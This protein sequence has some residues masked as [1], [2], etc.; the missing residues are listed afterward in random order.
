MGQGRS[1]NARGSV[2]WPA[3]WSRA[4]AGGCL[5]LIAGM[6]A[7]TDGV[8]DTGPAGA[9]GDGAVASRARFLMGTRLSI[10]IPARARPEVFEAAFAEV[11][12]LE[13]VMSNWRP[14]S[15]I[16]ALNRTAAARPFRCSVDLF[17]AVAASLRLAEETGGAFDPTV[18]PLVNR[19]GLRSADG[20]LPDDPTP[21][22]EGGSPPDGPVGW[23]HVR[24][25]P[26]HLSVFFDSPG[27]GIDLGGIGKGIAL[28]AA[29]R[30]LHEQGVRAALLDFGGQA[31]AVGA[32]PGTSGW[33]LGIAS[34]EDRETPRA[35]VLLKDASLAGSGNGERA[36]QS[37]GGSLGHILDPAT[38]SPAR[39]SGTVSVVAGDGT[40]AD[41]LSTALFVMGPDAGV[42]W[43]ETRGVSVQFAWV[44]EGGAPRV[45]GSS[46]FARLAANVAV[47]D[48]TGESP[49]E[50]P[51]GALTRSGEGP[52][53]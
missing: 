8:R 31:M 50:E 46:A 19:L 24:L 20:R 44:D 32:P 13:Q 43:A 2:A 4:L 16:M 25:D 35:A 34:P 38:R 21:A 28:D 41:A 1:V 36:V 9:E 37:P 30:I 3:R 29:A 10:E 40:T 33:A 23:Q 51:P 15:E 6:A 49:G 17:A 5:A 42:P 11:E 45:R 26:L 48:A 18:E 14:S 47:P 53:R 52:G 7:A 27:V 22:R 39:F 12:R